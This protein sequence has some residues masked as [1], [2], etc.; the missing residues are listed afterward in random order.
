MIFYR[1]LNVTLNETIIYGDND[2][3]VIS[4]LVLANPIAHKISLSFLLKN[5]D[6]L[7][8]RL[9]LI[10]RVSRYFLKHS[11]LTVTQYFSFF[12]LKHVVYHFEFCI[13]F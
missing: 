10:H 7:R 13:W 3:Q 4:N 11:K 2:W 6:M 9:V 5:F 8:K 1:L 12:S